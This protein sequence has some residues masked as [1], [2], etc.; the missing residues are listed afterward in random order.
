MLRNRDTVALLAETWPACFTVYERRRR[1][2]KLGIHHDILAALDG[3]ITLQV[4]RALRYYTGN[5]WY[6]R[7]TVAGAAPIGL[8][9]NPAGAV[10]AEEAAVAAARLASHKRNH[11]PARIPA[12]PPPKRISVAD[13]RQEAQLRKARETAAA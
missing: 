5:T 2:L 10:N 6:L 3:A 9:D 13:L 7:A 12:P 8:D 1:P 11:R 4:H